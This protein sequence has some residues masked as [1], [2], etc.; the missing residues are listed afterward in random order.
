MSEANGYTIWTHEHTALELSNKV[1]ELSNKL[2]RIEEINNE[3]GATATD[4]VDGDISAN[5]V[6][7]GDT[8]DTNTAGQY[9]VTYNV[10][11]AAMNA[12]TEV[13]RTVNVNEEVEP[14]ANA[15]ATAQPA[16]DFDNDSV[17]IRLWKEDSSSYEIVDGASETSLA[18]NTVGGTG[19]IMKYI[20]TGGQYANVQMVTCAKFD[21]ENSKDIWLIP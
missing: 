20:D 19:N 13:T 6:I 16:A 11:D 18:G 12:A 10:S 1:H 8:V 14:C 4:N 17:D 21:L 15:N 2:K 9:I 5:I 3:E 7:G